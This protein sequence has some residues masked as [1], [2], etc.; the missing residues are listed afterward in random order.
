MKTKILII[1]AVIFIIVFFAIVIYIK[2]E[3]NKPYSSKEFISKIKEYEKPD[4]T[5]SEQDLELYKTRYENLTFREQFAATVLINVCIIGKTKKITAID[6]TNDN[7]LN[8]IGYPD[9]LNNPI[10]ANEFDSV[11]KKLALYQ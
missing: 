4:E 8:E 6:F 10:T 7:F 1:A 3:K 2:S 5:S 9:M 11:S